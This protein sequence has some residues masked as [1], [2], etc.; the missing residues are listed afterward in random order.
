MPQQQE[1]QHV[2]SRTDAN[3]WESVLQQHQQQQQQLMSS[4]LNPPIFE[5][6]MSQ[7]PM[8]LARDDPEDGM[9]VDTASNSRATTDSVWSF[10]SMRDIHEFIR[11]YN[12]RR[13]NA[14]NTTYFLPAGQSGSPNFQTRRFA[15]L[16]V[17]AIPIL[18]F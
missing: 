3:L 1:Q 6:R 14:Q 16:L 10:E 11:E 9:T 17:P 18:P 4:S 12:G 2:N 7:L 8:N 5:P 13:Y 15:P